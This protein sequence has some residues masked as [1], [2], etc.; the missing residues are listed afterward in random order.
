MQLTEDMFTILESDF[1]N[2]P[3]GAKKKKNLGAREVK[4]RPLPFETLHL[5]GCFKSSCGLPVADEDAGSVR[6]G[7]FDFVTRCTDHETHAK[8]LVVDHIVILK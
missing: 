6:K 3:L 2:Q 8:G 4:Y 7:N 5:G 1:S